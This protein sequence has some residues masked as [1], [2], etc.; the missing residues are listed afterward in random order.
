MKYLIIFVV[1]LF[2]L[3]LIWLSSCNNSSSEIDY[4]PNI[5][6]SKDYIRAEDA[7]MEIVN[8]FYKGLRDSLVINHGY[9]YIDACDVSYH[10]ASNSLD[11]G[12]GVVDRL[13]QDNK[14]RK[15]QFHAIFTGPLFYDW[16][17]AD[18]ETD[19][20]FVDDYLIEASIQI[21]DLGTNGNNL[22]VFSVKVISSNIMLPDTTKVNG[23]R[24]TT[25]FI[26]IWE[27]GFLTPTIHEDDL[28][29]ITGGTSGFSSDGIEF[30]TEVQDALY[31]YADCFWIERGINL[32][33]VPSASIK[34]GEIDYITDDGCFNE[35]YFY[36]NGNLFYDVIK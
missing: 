10:S 23:V 32:I 15:G 9:G 33:T 12:Y 18:I 5:S 28:Y 34:T 36:F 26:F 30:S 7:I 3:P 16:V 31:N 19:S 27:E 29:L 4:N 11:F 22:P 20:L 2:C 35:M 8:S 13:C 17:T 21:Q 6:A 24:L 25:D 14:F 1:L